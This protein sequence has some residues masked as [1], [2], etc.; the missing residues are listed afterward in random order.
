MIPR[1]IRYHALVIDK[2][3]KSL[4]R[5]VWDFMRATIRA[6]L[7]TNAEAFGKPLRNILRNTRVFRMSDWRAVF[8]VRGSE[9]LIYAIRHRR[10]GY[11]GIERRFL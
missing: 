6:K 10:E 5:P 4:D 9:V 3:S 1:T 7:G 2:D 8:Q 11:E